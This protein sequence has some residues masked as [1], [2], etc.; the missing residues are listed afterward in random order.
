MTV[1]TRLEITSFGKFKN[2]VLELKP[3]LNELTYENEFG[4]STIADFILFILYGFTRTTSKKIELEDN[5]LKKYLPWNGEPILSGAMELE[6]DGKF[7]R[8]ERMQN[9]GRKKSVVM[10]NI[11]GA[12]L[13]ISDSP[14]KM[15]F[16]IDEETFSR[17]FLIRQTDIK[18]TGTGGLEA[19]LKNLVTTGD[20]DTS[21]E[22]ASRLLHKKM[23]KYRHVGRNSGRVFDIQ[24]ELSE[25]ELSK[26]EIKKE[27]SGL[28]QSRAELAD[29]S[30]KI[31]RLDAKVQKYRTMLPSARAHDAFG[32]LHNLK[33]IQKQ[34]S[35]Y[36][37]RLEAIREKEISAEKLQELAE[38]FAKRDMLKKSL[39][40]A[41][42]AKST[43][44]HELETALEE[45]PE[46]DTVKQ[47]E[48][49][50]A[51]L[52]SQK[53]RANAA[54]CS[55]GALAL[56]AA[57]ALALCRMIL[58]CAVTAALGAV[59]IICGF[60]FKKKIKVPDRLGMN[61]MQLTQA[62]E[63]YLSCRDKIERLE[64]ISV[65]AEAECERISAKVQENNIKCEAA[66]REYNAD[67]KSEL[68]QLTQASA[69][70]R[71]LEARIEALHEKSEELLEGGSQQALEAAAA[72]KTEWEHGVQETQSMIL[73]AVTE[74]NELTER[75]NRLYSI[76]ERSIKLTQAA[77]DIDDKKRELE[78]ELENA[79]YQIGVLETA[80][81]ALDEAYEYISDK[82][83]P[84]LTKSAAYPL[85]Q[86]TG[87]KYESVS[88]DRDFNLRV[89]YDGAMHE[90]GYFSR[91]TADAVYF[92]VRTAVS[93]LISGK[94][95]LPLIMDDPFWSLD[96]N[97]LQNA[98]T[99]TEKAAKSRQ[100]IIFSARK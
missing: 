6:S 60:V 55:A 83:T 52:I 8:I 87:G 63:S 90:L 56:T 84:L 27:L 94:S 65:H 32:K 38:V 22:K 36:E 10:R 62:Y 67:N 58:P 29:I 70:R 77:L 95:G 15:L 73:S 39:A 50:I 24:K 17:T 40:E 1:I 74:I 41:Q 30:E 75:Q 78:R 48:R 98:R 43:A 64:A 92:A 79:V 76:K 5:L 66:G 82:Y 53:P 18:F 93:D 54:L 44:A 45:C 61:Y 97:R 2:F 35:V 14:G 72:G 68:S 19:A 16:G 34:I 91:G 7:L 89:K 71:A 42:S 47:N 31:N 49:E 99:F 81:N 23:T 96:D 37:N 25:L 12:E 9:D 20:E 69:D 57:F 86:I 21:Y 46:Y 80:A 51:S 13:E 85:S 26:S 3:G 28:S 59:L 88:L 33:E 100:I 11:G 4:K